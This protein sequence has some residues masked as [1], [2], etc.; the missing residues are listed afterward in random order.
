MMY[1]KVTSH[2]IMAEISNI[3]IL[4]K[5]RVIKSLSSTKQGSQLQLQLILQRLV[6]LMYEYIKINNVSSRIVFDTLLFMRKI[7][8][9]SL[10][11]ACLAVFGYMF[12]FFFRWIFHYLFI[13]IFVG[14]HGL[15]LTSAETVVKRVGDIRTLKGHFVTC[16]ASQMVVQTLEGTGY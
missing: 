14:G 16:N 7:H 15:V 1:G 5:N 11:M 6:P 4:E 2:L 12:F 13:F 8:I 9:P 3:R 10:C